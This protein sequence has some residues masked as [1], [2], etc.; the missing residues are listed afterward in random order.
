MLLLVLAAGGL[1]G[2]ASAPAPLVADRLP[3]SVDGGW[4]RLEGASLAPGLWD[5]QARDLKASDAIQ[6][7]YDGPLRTRVTAYAFPTSANAFEMSQKWRREPL[8]TGF[9]KERLFVVAEP[10]AVTGEPTNVQ[11]QLVRFVTALE[12]KL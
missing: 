3:L 5:A 2:C 1:L 12:S 4:R 11:Q 10:F 6:A 7:V 9:H 8:R